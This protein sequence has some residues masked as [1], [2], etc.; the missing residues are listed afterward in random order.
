MSFDF[1]LCLFVLSV[2]L[3]FLSWRRLEVLKKVQCPLII[4]LKITFIYVYYVL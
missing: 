3:A 2:V 1:L 4:P